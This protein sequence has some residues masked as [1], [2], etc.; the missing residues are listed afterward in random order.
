VSCAPFQ[1]S[2][3]TAKGFNSFRLRLR[4]PT[5]TT[6]HPHSVDALCA[7]P[8]TYPSSQNTILTGSSDGLLRVIELLPTR[9]VG[10]IADHGDFPIERIAIDR[11]GEGRWVGSAGHDEA[12]RLTD[13]REVLEDEDERGAKAE[14]EDGEGDASSDEGGE[15]PLL[16][17]SLVKSEAADEEGGGEQESGDEPDAAKPRKRRKKGEGDLKGRPQ[18]K[19][20]A[21]DVD[22]SFFSGL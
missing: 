16:G 15:G 21:V 8:S 17:L 18:K 19:K 10:V 5:P 20:N 6:R 2:Y 3:H 11:A 4:S 13:L 22:P 14:D 9:L 1:S 12:L 7:L